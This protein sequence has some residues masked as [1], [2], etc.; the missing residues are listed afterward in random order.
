[1]AVAYPVLFM[2]QSTDSALMVTR[3][4]P[5]S[6]AW[7]V[8]LVCLV[9]PKI[10]IVMYSNLVRGVPLS[11]RGLF[12]FLQQSQY[13]GSY[14]DLHDIADGDYVDRPVEAADS[15][16]ALAGW[17]TTSMDPAQPVPE[18]KKFVFQKDIIVSSGIDRSF[19]NVLFT[20]VSELWKNYGLRDY[21]RFCQPLLPVYN[22]YHLTH[23]PRMMVTGHRSRTS[24]AKFDTELMAGAWKKMTHLERQ[25]C[26]AVDTN[27]AALNVFKLLQDSKNIREIPKYWKDRAQAAPNELVPLS[28]LIPTDKNVESAQFGERFS[29]YLPSES[30]LHDPR[31]IAQ[32]FDE[33]CMPRFWV[34]TSAEILRKLEM[35][36]REPGPAQLTEEGQLREPLQ[37]T[38]SRLFQ[39]RGVRY[40][41]VTQLISVYED[42]KDA[43][44]GLFYLGM[45]VAQLGVAM[46]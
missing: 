21:S 44:D 34:H 41:H 38:W 4:I 17:F 29:R 45:A 16:T 19:Q 5:A 3:Y 18:F 27:V 11:L 28:A 10:L 40:T 43:L 9:V 7:I 14:S 13:F 23:I 1:M 24:T 35:A 2:S 36:D 25:W 30:A 31:L 46:N 32:V 26:L 42:S 33:N 15:D 6:A 39:M 12:M 20:G 37:C 8:T 22:E